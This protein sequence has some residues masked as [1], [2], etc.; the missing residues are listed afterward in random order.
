MLSSTRTHC[1]RDGFHHDTKESTTVKNKT[2]YIC[3][4]LHIFWIISI[5]QC[6]LSSVM[7]CSFGWS[8]LSR[9]CVEF[10]HSCITVAALF[11]ASS[12]MIM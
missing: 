10:L 9:R 4:K 1:L 2:I 8:C 7:E 3:G 5:L 6:V 12:Y 11:L